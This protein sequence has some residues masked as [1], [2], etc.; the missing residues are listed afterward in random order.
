[1]EETCYLDVTGATAATYGEDWRYCELCDGYTPHGLCD[2]AD[3][4]VCGWCHE[5]YPDE[6]HG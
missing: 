1:M 5:S 2:I 6:Y 3:E 4:S